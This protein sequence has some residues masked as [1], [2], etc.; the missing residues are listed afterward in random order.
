MTS[1]CAGKPPAGTQDV[2]LALGFD[3]AIAKEVR[4]PLEG[5][6]MHRRHMLW[7]W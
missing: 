3:P 6:G 1:A 7:V 5:P 2:L 4:E